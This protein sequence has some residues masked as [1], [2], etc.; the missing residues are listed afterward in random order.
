MKFRTE[1]HRQP[2]PLQL[3]YGSS[4]LALGSCFAERIG[5][6]LQYAKF[7]SLVNPL[8]ILYNPISMAKVIRTA[9]GT[10]Q[11]APASFAAHLDAWH[12]FDLH[13][14][15]D[16]HTEAAYDAQFNRQMAL[17][18][19]QLGKAEVLILTFGTAWAYR[20]LENQQLVANC[21]QYPATD[22]QKVLL[23]LPEMTESM[24][25][26]IRDLQQHLPHLRILLT[27]SP[28]RHTREGLENNAISKALLRLLTHQL[29]ES[30]GHIHYFPAYEIMQ[31]DLRDYRFYGPDLIHPNEVAEDYLWEVFR[32]RHFAPDTEEL[33]QSWTQIARDLKHRPRRPGTEPHRQFL[34][35][36][37]AKLRNLPP[38]WNLEQEFQQVQQQWE[39]WF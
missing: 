13:S 9:L 18:R 2:Q 31:D 6:R 16:A 32:S 25:T 33:Y 14:D 23:S 27:V 26:L 28:V 5:L 30:F 29:N 17:F 35:Q 10:D 21:H 15:M 34:E 7:D 39:S 24:Y 36:L 38:R 11:L 4:L 20:H 3:T 8:G 37:E 12:S 22:F 19:D 1:I